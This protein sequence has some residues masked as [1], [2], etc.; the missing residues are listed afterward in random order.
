MALV[1]MRLRR[2]ALLVVLGSGA[3]FASPGRPEAASLP[4]VVDVSADLLPLAARALPPQING[5]AAIGDCDGDGWPDLYFPAYAEHI[6]LRNEN[7]QRFV[8]VT[9]QTGLAEAT[10]NLLFAGRGAAWGDV[11]N[12]GDLDLFVTGYANARHFLFINDGDCRFTEE[13]AQRGVAVD[14]LALGRSA[15]FGDFDRD[16][17]VDL[18]VTEMQSDLVNPGVP[19]PV[20][21]LFR[22]RG[23]R[24][25]GFFEDVTESSGVPLDDVPGS[26][27]GTFPFTPRFTDFD[28]D[29]WPDLAVASDFFESRLFWNRRDG[30]FEDGTAAAGTTSVEYGMGAVSA[31]FDGDGLL[32]WFVTSIFL[33]GH[34]KGTGNRLYRYAGGRRFV[35]IT[36]AAG[37]RDGGWGWGAE[38][39]DF[40]ND[41]DLDLAMTNGT[42]ASD[43]DQYAELEFGPVDLSQFVNDP[44]RFWVNQGGGVFSEQA[45]QVGFQDFGV[46]NA[47]VSFDFDRDGDLDLLLVHDHSVLPVLYRND[48]GNRNSWMV[49]AL[50]GHHSNSFGI[51]ARVTLSARG[52]E[53]VREVSASS[54]LYGQNGNGW[55]HF[56]LSGA[57]VVDWV[58]IDWPSGI[59]QTVRDLPARQ[60][61]TI[62][63]PASC[64]G[65]PEEDCVWIPPGTPTPTP[66]CAG[67]CNGDGEVTVDEI[68]W[69]VVLA[70]SGGPQD[71]CARGDTNRDGAIT[72][73]EVIAAV[74]RALAGCP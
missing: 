51:G 43:A 11:D 15:S 20:S 53:Q 64:E 48:G 73:D 61:S 46:G 65:L 60:Y 74:N 14:T 52:K 41:G 49:L 29:G 23:A 4:R 67:D 33:P 42:L 7:G 57:E 40:D 5:G 59:R 25:P 35:D 2:C 47:L 13:A 3:G 68:V 38:A 28:A 19:R 50:R 66:A 27:P 26:Q 58:R 55:V 12:D 32:D 16:G 70:L 10:A 72:V 39:L 62:G 45:T 34:Q 22:N 17:Y 6:L 63:E 30:T 31:D 54:T 8:D 9:G 37:V 44:A 18:F 1:R 24:A 71:D 69:L 56:G 21:H 36:E